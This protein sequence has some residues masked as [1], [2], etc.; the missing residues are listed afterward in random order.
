MHSVEI[1]TLFPRMVEAPL[2][3]SILGK[4]R[5]RGL[6]EVEVTDIRGFA[7]GRHRVCDDAPYGGGAGMVMKVEPLVAAI[8]AARAKRPGAHVVLLSPRGRVL[9]QAVVRELAS[10]ESLVLLCGRYEGVD[11]RVVRYVDE[12]V[13]LGDF[14]LTGGEVAALAVLDAVARLWPGVLGNAES[15][16][17]ESF[18]DGLIEHPHYTRPPEFRGEK[19]PEV[20]LSGDHAKV[21]RW[22]QGEALEATRGPA[23]GPLGRQGVD[24]GRRAALGRAADERGAAEERGAADG[25]RKSCKGRKRSCATRSLRPS[26]AKYLRKDFPAFRPGDVV[27]V[28][29]KIREGGKERVQAFEGSGHPQEAPSQPRHLHRAEGELLGGRGAHL[30]PSIPRATRRSKSSPRGGCGA[31]GLFYLRGLQGK[32]ARVQAEREQQ[33]EAAPTPAPAPK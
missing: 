3:E 15:A 5:A 26:R 11:E 10:H 21:E 23:A 28:H 8:E 12:E 20:L 16:G 19:V 22:A 32:A 33:T 31:R 2:T 4:A 13:S 17:K 30:P 7:E 27:R 1:L 24:E 25:R 18:E 6:F 14:V 29:W 9:R